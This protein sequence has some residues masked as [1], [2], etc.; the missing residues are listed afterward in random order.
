MGPVGRGEEGSGPASVNVAG[1]QR[2]HQDKGRKRLRMETSAD[3]DDVQI[4]EDHGG[5]ED[6]GPQQAGGKGQKPAHESSNS[7]P[8]PS[9]D[10]KKRGKTECSD[11]GKE[12]A[13]K[14]GKGK[15]F[16]FVIIF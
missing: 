4:L 7:A 9:R 1:E 8:G 5:D 11:R 15:G 16:Q 12:G 14:K 3:D 10:T 6:L 13:Q 2:R